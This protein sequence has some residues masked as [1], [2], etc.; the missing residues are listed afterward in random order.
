[1]NE[2]TPIITHRQ[3]L[4]YETRSS[5]WAGLMFCNFLQ[6]IAARYFARKVN[7]KMTRYIDSKLKTQNMHKASQK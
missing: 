4:E 2:Y 1:M 7:S 3:A 6:E 5:S